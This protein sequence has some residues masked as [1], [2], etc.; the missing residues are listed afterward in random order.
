VLV[1]GNSASAS[2]I[3][4]GALKNNDRALIIGQQ[5][6]GKGS[7][8]LVFSDVTP[9]KAALKLTIA[10][11]LTPG[12][13]SIQGVGVVPDIELDP[14]TVDDLEMDL[15]VHKDGLRERDLSAHLSNKRAVPDSKPS[16][17]VRYQ[18]PSSDREAMRE[19]GG[20]VDEEFQFDFPIRFARD[21][22]LKLPPGQ[23]RLDQLRGARDFIE[24]TRRE[25]LTK[26]TSELSRLGADWSEPPAAAAA[27]PASLAATKDLE[28]KVDTDRPNA[29]VNAGEPMELRVTVKNNG[30]QPVYR[31]RAT[32][33]SDSGYFEGKEL[34]FG[35]IAGG[36]SKTAKAPLGWCEV[37][38]RK[39]GT[40]KPR[41]KNAKRVCK[42]PM[43]ALTRND[44][45]RVKFDA[46]GAEPAPVEI[47]PTVHALDRP[48]FQYT[49][50]IADDR[51]G[52]GDGKL[53]KGE[54][55]TMYL[56]VKNTGKGRSFETQA[57]ISNLSGDG[58][59]LRAGRFDVSNMMPG[60]VRKVAFTFDVLPSLAE[61]E[62]TLS[63]SVTDRDLREFASEK[64]K[65]PIEPGLSVARATGAVRA[66]PQGATLLPSP[67]ANAR[68]FGRLLP[69]A[70]VGLLGRIGEMNKVDLGGGRFA[71]VSARD[72]NSGG[73]A[74][75][76]SFED[77]YLHAPPTI[78]VRAAT[79]ATKDDRVK[80]TG[81]AS[82]SERLMDLY[83][84]VG[85]RK[86]YYKSNRDGAD[87]KKTSFEFDAPLRPGVNLITVVA[88][89]TP[90]T[91]SRRV[92]A[93]RKDGADG[94]ILKTPKTDDPI[95]DGAVIDGD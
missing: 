28:V 7:V 38:G 55:V 91:T 84:F 23:K 17:V 70:T 89:E 8:Q 12:D 94:S 63:L 18:L 67:D 27:D 81:L 32:T 79:M 64:V 83:V 57:N 47:R 43:D 75:A 82:D 59:L 86:L 20:D 39:G 61:P 85:S 34:I 16:E 58:L 46:A 2:E 3:V 88:R 87:P 6:F 4:A 41:D 80:I 65:I 10:Q 78:D 72:V 44:G 76:V 24:Q 11:Y 74:G 53:Q 37:E 51:A 35:K 56:T 33:E 73:A 30:K 92:I 29:E 90:D 9:E 95:N 66:G 36:Q 25:E 54:Q 1:N 93:V 31:L 52:N 14:M 22:A 13:V 49:Y 21:L 68:G 60:D 50:Q 48:L 26:V 69:G 42:I 45:L 71:F 5:T 19:R 62:A 77:V 15:T 40:T